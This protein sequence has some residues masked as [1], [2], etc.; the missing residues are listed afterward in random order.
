MI[1]FFIESN[2]DINLKNKK[3]EPALHYCCKCNNLEI[4][5]YL[6]LKWNADTTVKNTLGDSP[7]SIA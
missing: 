7:I 4:A 1:D 5:K 3:G 2:V 6:V